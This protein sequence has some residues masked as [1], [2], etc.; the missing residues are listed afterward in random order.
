MTA[1][2]HEYTHKPTGTKAAHVMGFMSRAIRLFECGMKPIFVFDGRSPEMKARTLVS[3]DRRRERIVGQIE[4]AI[5]DGD[6]TRADQL[7]ARLIKP[8]I[9]QYAEVK[10]ML[11]L[12]GFPVI[13]APSEAEATCAI[14]AKHG[15]VSAGT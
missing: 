9:Q 2:R 11:E 3:R 1:M 13:Q 15:V 7:E 4:K 12:M 14:L 8:T 5:A 6:E 10:N